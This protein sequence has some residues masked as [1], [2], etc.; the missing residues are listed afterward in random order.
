VLFRSVTS[1]RD[2]D[3]LIDFMISP[4]AMLAKKDPIAVKLNEKYSDVRMPDLSLS[5]NDAEDLLDYLA[6]MTKLHIASKDLKAAPHD[7][8]SHKHKRVQAKKAAPHDHSSHNHKLVQNK[9]AA[10]PHDH[11]SHTH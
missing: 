9:K 2:R 5:K 11:S 10:P 8:S 7:H 1:R 4:N 6:S 3:W